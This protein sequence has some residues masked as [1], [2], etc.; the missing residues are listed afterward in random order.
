M[1]QFVILRHLRP[2]GAH[3]DFMLEA[4]GVLKTWALSD[5]PQPGMELQCEA[6]AD[7]RLAYLDYEGPISG[8]RGSVERCDCGTYFAEEQ[9]DARWVVR[10]AGAKLAGIV[11]L[12]RQQDAPTRWHFSFADRP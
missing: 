2:Q 4:G 7:H 8:G 10:L 12:R 5:W 6:L 11:T 3:F 9:D 1:P